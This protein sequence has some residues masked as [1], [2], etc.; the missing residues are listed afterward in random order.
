MGMPGAIPSAGGGNLGLHQGALR[1][2]KCRQ[3]E[4]DGKSLLA[5]TSLQGGRVRG[6]PSPA[7]PPS[8]TTVTLVLQ[9]HI[10]SNVM[11]PSSP[12]SD[13]EYALSACQGW[14]DAI[15]KST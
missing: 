14:D 3:G 4:F 13:I 6:T 9:F 5:G 15:S 11:V 2:G 8:G 1:T 7:C 10:A 12:R